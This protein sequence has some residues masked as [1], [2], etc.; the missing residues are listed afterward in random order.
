MRGVTISWRSSQPDDSIQWGYSE[1]YEKG[2]FTGTRRDDYDIYLYDF[3]FPQI[4]PSSQI[5]YSIKSAENWSENMVFNTAVDTSSENFTFI[6]GSDCHGGDDDH[7][8]NSR[9]KLMSE[10]V[11]N[12]NSDFC[13]L[14][15]DVVDD[16]NDW[17]LWKQFYEYGDNLLK[18]KIIF[19]TWGNHEYGPMALHNSVLPGN[20][21]WYSFEQGNALFISL[22]SEEDFEMQ[23]EWLLDQLGST[24]KDW[25][26]VYFHRPFFLPGSHS[27]EMVDYRETWWKAFDDYGVDI[28]ISGHRHCYIRSVPINLN[29]SDTAAVEIYGSEPGYGRLEL[30][31]SGLGGKNSS[32]STDW[33][34]ADS[35]SG[36]HY[37][38]IQ[39]NESKLHFDTYSHLGEIIDSL[40][41]YSSGTKF[42][43]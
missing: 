42:Q 33:F 6:V 38:K 26:I 19:Y 20:E 5:H 29:V 23:H 27:H 31:V 1:A 34:S 36:L 3:T 15:G 12:E 7:D 8:S 41:I 37:V 11:L 4:K 14:A 13:I 43:K 21:K 10:L 32:E 2:K 16:D 40:T 25:I 9:W 24:D 18:N 17:S 39:I 30:V 35:Y 28:V 22:L